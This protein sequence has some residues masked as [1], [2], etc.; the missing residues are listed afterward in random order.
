MGLT[1]PTPHLIILRAMLQFK[2]VWGEG[3]WMGCILLIFAWNA[4]LELRHA[5]LNYNSNFVTFSLLYNLVLCYCVKN[6]RY[7]ENLKQFF[8]FL[9]LYLG[10]GVRS[11]EL[12]QGNATIKLAKWS[13]HFLSSTT[14]WVQSLSCEHPRLIP[15]VAF[16]PS[17]SDSLKLYLAVICE[18]FAQCP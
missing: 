6:T 18:L 7:F 17:N 9:F 2:F 1:V 12:S 3:G 4:C 16:F 5:V 10:V 8:F 13:E 15:G 14:L 11:L